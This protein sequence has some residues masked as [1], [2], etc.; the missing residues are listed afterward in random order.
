MK[1]HISGSFTLISSL[2]K[3]M[4]QMTICLIWHDAYDFLLI[5]FA[6]FLRNMSKNK[7]FYSKNDF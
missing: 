2:I 6:I 1:N 7:H 4:S 5:L 3:V